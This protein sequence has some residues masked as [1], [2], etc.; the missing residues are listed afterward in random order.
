MSPHPY[1]H[2]QLHVLHHRT[3]P[4]YSAGGQSDPLSFGSVAF[5]SVANKVTRRINAAPSRIL[6]A[7]ELVDD[8][9][10]ILISWRRDNIL[11]VA[12]GQCVYLWNAA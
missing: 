10:L 3:A 12:L 5:R 2:D 9:Y 1:I 7:P 11:A 4:G 8:Y 6:D